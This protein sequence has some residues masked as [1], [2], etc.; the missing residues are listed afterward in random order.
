M[1]A[2]IVVM[3]N[4]AL[5]YNVTGVVFVLVNNVVLVDDVVLMLYNVLMLNYSL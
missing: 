5:T 4:F 1:R 3:N 2:A